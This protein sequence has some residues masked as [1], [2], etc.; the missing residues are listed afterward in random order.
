MELIDVARSSEAFLPETIKNA[1]D[2][3]RETHPHLFGIQE[4]ELALILKQ[5]EMTPTPV[6]NR[7][8]Y[9][10]WDRY[11]NAQQSSNFQA[12]RVVDLVQGIC[13]PDIFYRYVKFPEKVAW[14]MCVPTRYMEMAEEA[15]LFGITQLRDILEQPHMDSRGKL[16][17]Q[18][19]SMKLK[20]VALLYTRVKGAPVQRSLN[21]HTDLSSS[22]AQ[23]AMIGHAETEEDLQKRVRDYELREKRALHITQRAADADVISIEPG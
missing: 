9:R 2:K 12:I 15:L 14:L 7:L 16:N 10:L 4:K 11:E 1:L 22:A 20:V 6:D 3:H 17:V 23:A 21:I 18:L 8:R 19:M 5:S 13:H